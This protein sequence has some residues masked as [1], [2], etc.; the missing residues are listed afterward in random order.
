V[1]RKSSLDDTMT[2][3]LR[4]AVLLEC[5]AENDDRTVFDRVTGAH[6]HLDG[7]LSD[8]LTHTIIDATAS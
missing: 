7:L 6:E 8:E 5:Q 1:R 3:E 2:L 4:P